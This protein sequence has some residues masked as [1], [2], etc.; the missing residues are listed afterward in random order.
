MLKLNVFISYSSAIT[1]TNIIL[2]II[3]MLFTTLA[4]LL[5]VGAKRVSTVTDLC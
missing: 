5:I 1:I 2:A 3:A 4:V